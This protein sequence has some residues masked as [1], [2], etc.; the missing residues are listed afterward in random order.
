MTN[1]AK[2]TRERTKGEAIPAHGIDWRRELH[3]R[4]S[5]TNNAVRF[6]HEA[7]CDAF[8]HILVD[9]YFKQKDKALD[10]IMLKLRELF[11]TELCYD[12]DGD[13]ITNG[14][15]IGLESHKLN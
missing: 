13:L 9:S 3:S 8:S 15:A 14:L 2:G 7:F 12:E 10:Y 4:E 6:N 11:D 5:H 1:A